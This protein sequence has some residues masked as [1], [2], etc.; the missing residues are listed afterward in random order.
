MSFSKNI[1]YVI[2]TRYLFNFHVL[3]VIVRCVVSISVTSCRMQLEESWS[4]VYAQLLQSNLFVSLEEEQSVST[5][6]L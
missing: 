4:V 1:K 5:A 6:N 2:F 3:A